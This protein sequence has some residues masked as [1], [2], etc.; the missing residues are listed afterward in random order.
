L[1]NVAGNICEALPRVLH[2]R[3]HD[4]GVDDV[5]GLLVV[6]HLPQPRRR[7]HAK[8]KLNLYQGSPTFP[9]SA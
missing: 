1:D 4:L 3:V 9:F 8:P 7:V 6:D 5:D 2:L